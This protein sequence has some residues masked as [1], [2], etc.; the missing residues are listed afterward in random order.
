MP[1]AKVA[2]M[3]AAHKAVEADNK[4]VQ[5]ELEEKTTELAELKTQVQP[6][7]SPVGRSLTEPF[8][9]LRTTSAPY[10]HKRTGRQR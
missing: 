7:L 2:A 5:A 1:V 6:D 3:E 8:P 4:R 10:N 9:L